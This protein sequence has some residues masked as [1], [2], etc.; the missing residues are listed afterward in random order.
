MV[1]FNDSIGVVLMFVWYNR[2]FLR[3]NFNERTDKLL[4]RMSEIY[5]KLETPLKSSTAIVNK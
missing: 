2:K 1:Q 3:M 4:I 5:F